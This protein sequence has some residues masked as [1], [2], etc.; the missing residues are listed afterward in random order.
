MGVTN[1]DVIGANVT[2]ITLDWNYLEDLVTAFG[3]TS[4]RT[5]WFKFSTSGSTT[6]WN[7]T[8]YDSPTDTE[9]DS[10][11]SWTGPLPFDPNHSYIYKIDFDKNSQPETWLEDLGVISDD[12]GV[13]IDFDNGC[14]LQ[15]TAVYRPVA[16]SSA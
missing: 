14:Q 7:G 13:T 4:L 1:G 8:D 5:D 3:D 11:A 12:F 9:V 16:N 6:V 15:R 2:A 10:P